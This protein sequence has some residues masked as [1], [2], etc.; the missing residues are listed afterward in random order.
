VRKAL[1][2]AR[3]VAVLLLG[4]TH[5]LAGEIR[6]QGNGQVEYLRVATGAYRQ[7]AGK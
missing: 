2:Q 5:D 3:P 7:V 4:G 6:R 1:E